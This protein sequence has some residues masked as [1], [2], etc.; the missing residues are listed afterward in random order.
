MS[1]TALDH[2]AFLASLDADERRRLCKQSDGPGLIRIATHLGSI[3]LIGVYIAAGLSFWWLAM[4][5]QGILIVFLFTAL[6]ECIHRTAFETDWINDRFADLLGGLVLLGPRHFRYFHMAHHRF[7]H[8][9]D[10]DPELA[11][12]KPETLYALVKYLSGVSDWVWRIRKLWSNATIE[13]A[14]PYVPLRGRRRVTREARAILA[15]YLALAAASWITGTALLLWVWLVP[16]LIGG[17]FLRAYL[18]AEHARCPHVS[19][20]FENTR[21][22]FTSRLVRWLAWNMP[23]HAE[24]HAYP[25]VPFHKLPDLH[26][27]QGP[28]LPQGDPSALGSSA[29][30]QACP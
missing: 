26:A 12:G 21:T 11:D 4:L 30:G 19:D 5:P 23:Y 1:E 29:H 25:A 17:P 20:M 24:H 28:A 7:T 16:L 9:P 18:L 2:R 3:I 8:D 22:T 27:V 10:H 13:N 15:T 6:H 14:D